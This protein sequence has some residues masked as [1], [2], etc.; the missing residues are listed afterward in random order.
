[1]PNNFGL[2][3]KIRIIPKGQKNVSPS[4]IFKRMCQRLQ[5]Q[6]Q[7]AVKKKKKKRRKVFHLND[8]KYN[9]NKC[10][11]CQGD[12]LLVKVGQH[13]LRSVYLKIIHITG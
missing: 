10:V 9:L 4:D 5:D 1:M 11:A 7:R 3:T 6:F 12:Y 13:P 2:F 8:G